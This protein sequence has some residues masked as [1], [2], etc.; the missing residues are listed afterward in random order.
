MELTYE[1]YV[2]DQSFWNEKVLTFPK[3]PKRMLNSDLRKVN[4]DLLRNLVANYDE[5][6]DVVR[7]SPYSYCLEPDV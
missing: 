4:P 2:Q 3:I 1:E 7:R 5:I 6:A